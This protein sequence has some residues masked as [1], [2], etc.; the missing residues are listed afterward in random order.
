MPL[1]D[2]MEEALTRA[3]Q[4]AMYWHQ[5][6]VQRQPRERIERLAASV[7]AAQSYDILLAFFQADLS[8]A[9]KEQEDE[10]KIAAILFLI[11]AALAARLGRDV[12]MLTPGL[13]DALRVALLN[14]GLTRYGINADIRAIDAERYLRQHG[15]ELVKGINEFTMKELREVLARGLRE[16]V[17]MEDLASRLMTKMDDYRL[18][19]ARRIAVTESS[20]A[21]SYAEMESAGRME[22]AGYRMVKEWLLGPAHPRYDICDHNHEEG[23]IPLNRSFSSGDMAPPQHPNCGCSLITYPAGGDQPWGTQVLG[24]LPFMPFGFDQGDPNANR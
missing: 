5:T 11:A 4:K 14:G 12:A 16:G 21:W 17:S 9:T 13:E 19:R 24:G 2:F 18:Y 22:D 1:T 20:K 23:A 3:L 6:D 7:F 10:R 15:A 8:E